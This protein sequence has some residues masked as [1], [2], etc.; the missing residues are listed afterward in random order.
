MNTRHLILMLRRAEA[1]LKR[2]DAHELAWL[3]GRC[4]DDLHDGEMPAADIRGL[5]VQL[6]AD[7]VQLA[8]EL[9][10]ALE[11]LSDEQYLNQLEE[12]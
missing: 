1:R 4:A 11:D 9:D 7:H 8:A 10:A 6:Q 12:V 5:V 3:A 2:A